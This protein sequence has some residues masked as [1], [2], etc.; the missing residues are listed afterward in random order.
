MS[1]IATLTLALT[2]AGLLIC[3]CQQYK[4]VFRAGHEVATPMSEIR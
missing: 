1:K 3:S 4:P 2:A